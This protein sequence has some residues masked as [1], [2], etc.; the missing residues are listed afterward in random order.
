MDRRGRFVA[1]YLKD[2]PSV[3]ELCRRFGSSRK[4][5]HEWI[6]R[7]REQGP[8]RSSRYLGRAVR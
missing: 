5:G 7:Y 4:T 3:A 2:E 1:E 6:N 8:V